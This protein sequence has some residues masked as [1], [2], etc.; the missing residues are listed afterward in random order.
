[1]KKELR[2]YVSEEI[3]TLCIKN[4]WYTCGNNRDYEHLLTDLVRKGN[5]MQIA[6]DIYRHSDNISCV[7]E[8]YYAISDI[9]SNAE[10][11]HAMCELMCN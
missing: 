11:A 7:N 4:R 9:V 8:P 10:A 6:N 2:Y 3:R 5:V 1:M